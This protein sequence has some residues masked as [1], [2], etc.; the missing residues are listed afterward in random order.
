[1][2]VLHQLQNNEK[3]IP[4][5]KSCNYD[6]MKR[7]WKTVNVH[8]L[9]QQMRP[10][11]LPTRIPTP[12]ELKKAFNK[13]WSREESEMSLMEHNH[14]CLCAYDCFIT[15]PRSNEDIARIKNSPEI[16]VQVPNS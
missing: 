6:C 13:E 5:D 3:V 9:P 7:V 14:G 8:K 11:T 10:S 16:I 12:R 4:G 2:S 1:M 15:G